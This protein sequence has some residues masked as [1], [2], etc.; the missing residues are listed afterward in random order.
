MN[1]IG[2][3]GGTFNPIHLGHL[4]TVREVQ[5]AYSLERIIFIPSANPPHK[6]LN[7]LASADDRLQMIKLAICQISDFDVS[8]VE[9]H[10]EGPSYTIDTIQYFLSV[11]PKDT[12]VFLI[13][14][15]DAFF[16]IHTWKSYLKIFLLVPLI[17]MT[18]PG[19]KPVKAF[20]QYLK[21][22]I[23]DGYQFEKSIQAYIHPHQQTVY[24]F[25]PTQIDI[26]STQI[27]KLIQSGRS[28]QFLTPEM[29]EGYIRQ[30]G[31]YQ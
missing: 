13:I 16:E 27:R 5:E 17:I 2:L 26:S 28:I 24:S 12:Q 23:S 7:N 15:H 20:E 1:R 31:L 22:T 4:R 30:K 3:F 21:Q 11:Y 19:T 18:R 25:E 10:R 6:N 9:L 14:G 29:V 8:D